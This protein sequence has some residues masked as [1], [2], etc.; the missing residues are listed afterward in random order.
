M[1]VEKCSIFCRIYKKNNVVQCGY[2]VT[3]V[4][5]LDLGGTMWHRCCRVGFILTCFL[6][7]LK[8]KTARQP[9]V[10]SENQIIALNTS[11]YFSRASID[12]DVSPSVRSGLVNMGYPENSPYEWVVTDT[13]QLITHEVPSASQALRLSGS[14]L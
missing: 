7:P 3:R 5:P 11:V 9:L 6:Y 2:V 12:P 13:M 14:E 1:A 10:I 8:Y 4:V